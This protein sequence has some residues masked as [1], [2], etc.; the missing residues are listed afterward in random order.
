VILKINCVSKAERPKSPCRRLGFA[1]RLGAAVQCFAKH[2]FEV[3]VTE[4]F[5][6]PSK[7]DI[8]YALSMLM[9][10]ARRQIMEERGRIVSQAAA[11]SC[12]QSNRV[13][14]LVADAADRI[15][16]ASLK[17]AT[18]MLR[19]FIERMERPS[20]EITEWARPHLENLSNSVLGG[21]PPNG[22]PADHQRIIGQYR[23]IFQQ[24]VDGALREAEIGYIK[25]AGFPARAAIPNH[26]E[27]ISAAE[28]LA[29]IK[30]GRAICKRAHVGLVKARAARF[31]SAG[32][33]SDNVDVPTEMWWAEGEAA[34][35]QDW[36]SGDFETWI[37][38]TIRLQA[39]AVTFNRA[40]I[41]KIIPHQHIEEAEKARK[42][43]KTTRGNVFIGHGR[44]QVWL[45]LERFLGNRL[46][47]QVEEF[48]S[49]AGAGI[50]TASRL[51]EML[52]NAV[53][54][55]LVMT[56]EDESSDGKFNPRLNV[57]HEAGLF[58]GRLGF[59]KAII[60]LEE[61]CEEF[62]N[63][64]GLGQIRFPKGDVSSKFEEIRQTLEREG[65]VATS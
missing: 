50:P 17:Q 25:G 18:P 52:D 7:G 10:E 61:G 55:F 57:V 59:K 34:L 15:H 38:N 47:L 64:H 39:F 42:K 20:K 5:E 9:H 13:I 62:S 16:A 65:V 6:R 8:D 24:R 51:D 35:T 53:F 27:W 26:D 30:N 41:E 32:K 21:I 33:S 4:M 54:A 56:A 44:S 37:R 31:I 43:M 22:F 12:L 3:V 58:Q 14:V 1:G 36:K 63:I 11:A 46:K 19:D 60:L 49:S 45:Q 40:D 28:A 2:D 48:N 29:L 23:A